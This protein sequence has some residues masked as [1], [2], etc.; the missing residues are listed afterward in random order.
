MKLIKSK[1]EFNEYCK[2]YVW[3]GC[4][5]NNKPIK[6]PCYIS[7]VVQHPFDGYFLEF[8]YREDLKN[9]IEQLEN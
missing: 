7:S 8:L 2:K 1:I 6:Y 5:I 9:M 4:K 3:P